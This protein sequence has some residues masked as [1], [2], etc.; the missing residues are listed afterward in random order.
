MVKL[1]G[2]IHHYFKEAHE[3]FH[4]V[5]LPALAVVHPQ[6]AADLTIIDGIGHAVYGAL[7]HHEHRPEA[8]RTVEEP[9]QQLAEEQHQQPERSLQQSTLPER[10]QQ[11]PR[12]VEK[13]DQAPTLG[14]G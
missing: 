2:S 6:V 13:Q 4:L 3:Q 8:E 11:E 14:L 1:A 5:G 7:K 10:V 9:K 12:Q